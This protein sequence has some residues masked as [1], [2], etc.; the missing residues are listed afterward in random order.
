MDLA[1]AGLKQ[2]PFPTHGQPLAVLSY[3]SERAA[4]E[5]LNDTY[6]NR[7]GLSLLQG[8]ALSGKSTLIRNFISTLHEDCECALVDGQG[9]NTT[10]LLLGILRQFGYTLETNSANELLG[11]VRVFATQQAASHESPMLIIENTHE[12]NPSALRALCELADIRVRNGSALKIVL[13]SDRSLGEIIK[14]P[15]MESIASRLLHDFHLRPMSQAEAKE[16]LRSKLRVAGSDYP[17]FVFPDA[18]CARLWTA[19]GGWPGIMDR[20]ALLALAGAKTLPVAVGDVEQ[21][22]LPSGTWNDA[23]FA[24]AEPDPDPAAAPAAPRLVVTNNGSVIADIKMEKPRTLVGRS[25]HND[26]SIGSRFVS[27]HHTL[28]VRHGATTFLM[29]LNSTNGTFVNAKRVSNHIL[30]HRDVIMIGHHKIKFH[31]PH[32][33]TRGTLDG[34]EFADTAIIKTLDDMRTLL[35]QENTAILPATTEDLPTIQS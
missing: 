31:D 25:E 19:S 35:A 30:L 17:D 9:L 11:M 27:R 12:M 2:Q 28:F 32:A 16:Y 29:D 34:P 24:L 15:A 23:E 14:A 21:P 33:T 18:V 20:L 4:L 5:V 1:A 6:V 3:E 10:N 22:A 7:T 8:P 26:I 13:V